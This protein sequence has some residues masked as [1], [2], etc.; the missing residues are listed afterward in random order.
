MLVSEKTSDVLF[1]NYN[2]PQKNK[3]YELDN[4]LRVHIHNN[5][6]QCLNHPIFDNINKENIDVF[7]LTKL[8]IDD[9]GLSF[10]NIKTDNK[11]KHFASYVSYGNY[12]HYSED[13]ID[14][15]NA[16]KLEI[17]FHEIAHAFDDIFFSES[18]HESHGSIYVFTLM[19]LLSKYNVVSKEDFISLGN[20]VS[21]KIRVMDEFKFRI[22]QL[23]KDAMERIIK[24]SMESVD[25]EKS[26]EYDSCVTKKYPEYEL[27]KYF[28]KDNKNNT[29]INILHYDYVNSNDDKIIM[30]TYDRNEY[31]KVGFNIFNDLTEEELFKTVVFSPIH[32]L[33]CDGFQIHTERHLYDYGFMYFEIEES[34]YFN[35]YRNN[36]T[37]YN[38]ISRD[39]KKVA[40]DLKD[41][42]NK[43]KKEG[44]RVIKTKNI[45]EFEFYQAQ[46]CILKKKK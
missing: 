7:E 39:K 2:D 23:T 45:S 33:D 1:E 3:V 4:V 31:Q 13:A 40:Q 34:N 37:I 5:Y 24:D 41:I 44:Y 30:S 16:S 26:I 21:G 17:V 10:L 36:E 18:S 43:M 38:E 27:K 14:A 29:F 42:S 19:E 8:I 32:K 22:I 46:V 20:N 25:G 15:S 35:N 12:L 28:L 9:L 11:S 6:S